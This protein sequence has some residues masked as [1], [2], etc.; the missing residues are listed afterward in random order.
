MLRKVRVPKAIESH[1]GKPNIRMTT[2]VAKPVN[3]PF[4]GNAI[5]TGDRKKELRLQG[6]GSEG[7]PTGWALFRHSLL[8]SYRKRKYYLRMRKSGG[9]RGTQGIKRTSS[10]PFTFEAQGRFTS[11]QRT[12]VVCT[13]WCCAVSLF[14][15]LGKVSEPCGRK[16]RL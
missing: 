5:A 16:C 9:P 6:K 4:V 2:P 7:F 14:Q 1:V 8:V 10:R 12:G 13:F 11:E 3:K 15:A